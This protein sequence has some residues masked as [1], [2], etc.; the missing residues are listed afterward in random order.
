MG[1]FYTTLPGLYTLLLY[2][3]SNKHLRG[4][5]LILC[6]LSPPV[7][8]DTLRNHHIRYVYASSFSPLNLIL[9]LVFLLFRPICASILKEPFSVVILRG[10]Q[11]ICTVCITH[12]TVRSVVTLHDPYLLF[13]CQNCCLLSSGLPVP[14]A[15]PL[16][17]CC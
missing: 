15:D 14:R 7:L 3:Y 9:P 16:L 6:P 2:V 17:S 5:A 12:V 8:P 13:L 4:S 10:K 11:D 1:V